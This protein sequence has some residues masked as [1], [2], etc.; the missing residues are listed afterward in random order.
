MLNKPRFGNRKRTEFEALNQRRCLANCSA[1][2]LRRQSE[3]VDK[4]VLY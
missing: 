4:L 1:T 3:I 2:E